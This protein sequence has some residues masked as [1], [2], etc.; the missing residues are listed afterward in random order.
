MKTLLDPACHRQI[1]VRLW[2]LGRDAPA[3]WGSLTAPRMVVHLADQLRMTLG[4]VVV[5]PRRNVLHWPVIKPLVIY[6]L[7]W[8]RGRIKGSPQLFQSPPADWDADRSM[9]E[10]LLAR[11]LAD[12]RSVWP[13]HPYF[14]SMTRESWA[15]F[16]WRHFDHHF[17]QFGV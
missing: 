13:G 11:F 8:P 1:L 5:P 17:T 12:A 2:C 7:P 4:D 9:L 14:G 16:T 15:R 10:S 3:R 6:W